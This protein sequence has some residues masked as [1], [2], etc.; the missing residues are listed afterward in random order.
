MDVIRDQIEL[1][2]AEASDLSFCSRPLPLT[3]CIALDV[4]PRRM[5]QLRKSKY[6]DAGLKK[7]VTHTTFPASAG[8]VLTKKHAAK[9][10]L[11][12]DLQ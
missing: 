2:V 6:H 4:P 7:Y 8:G 9:V 11:V 5:D 3:G 10:R 12:E 1:A